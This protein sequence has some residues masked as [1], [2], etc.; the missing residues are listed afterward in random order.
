[1]SN[2]EKRKAK[3]VRG[4]HVVADKIG[5]GARKVG[6]WIGGAATVI[7]MGKLSGGKNSSNKV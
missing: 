2:K 6:P 3:F 1:M 4:M 7:I 5:K